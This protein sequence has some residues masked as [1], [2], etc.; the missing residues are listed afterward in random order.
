MSR[1]FPKR[2]ASVKPDPTERFVRAVGAESAVRLF[3]EFGGSTVYLSERPQAASKLASEM[4]EEACAG[5][6]R[7]FGTGTVNIPLANTWTARQL[8]K[9]GGS[10]A[11]IAR[12]LRVTRESVRTSL[13]P[14]TREAN[15]P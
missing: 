15:R 1:A 10:R 4:G 5:L 3:L 12:A 6:L 9:A 2:K 11:A 7:E 13:L 8:D 14:P